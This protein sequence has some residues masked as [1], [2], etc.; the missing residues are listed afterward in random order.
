MVNITDEGEFREG[1]Y[2]DV[3]YENLTTADTTSFY[4]ERMYVLSDNKGRYVYKKGEDGKLQ[5]QYI[6]TGRNPDGYAYEVLSG[7]GWDDYV[8]FPYG[9]DIEE[10]APVEETSEDE[11]GVG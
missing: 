3:K 6:V 1:D 2:V 11:Y 10:G 8:A 5:K 7:L 4:I 9:S